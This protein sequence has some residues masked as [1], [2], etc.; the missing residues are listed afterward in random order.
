M[1]KAATKNHERYQE[2][3]RLAVQIAPQ[4]PQD[5]TE[6][7]AVL[8][9]TAELIL[10]FLAKDGPPIQAAKAALSIVS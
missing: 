9:C 2:Y 3:R 10:T 4:L 8:M 6:A 7:M 1:S 5:P